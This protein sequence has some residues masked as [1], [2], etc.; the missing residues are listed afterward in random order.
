MILPGSPA[1][2]NKLF[3][4]TYTNGLINYFRLPDN[5]HG[6][7]FKDADIHFGRGICVREGSDATIVLKDVLLIFLT[8][9]NDDDL[10]TLVQK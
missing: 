7:E 3:K 8:L 9:V 6:V 1:E 5:A 10:H 2:F 4:E